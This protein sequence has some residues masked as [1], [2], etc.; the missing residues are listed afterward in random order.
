MFF[1]GYNIYLLELI[2]SLAFI[3]LFIYLEWLSLIVTRIFEFLSLLLR[4]HSL[5]FL[6][7]PIY[8][9]SQR[10]RSYFLSP[11]SISRQMRCLRSSLRQ[12]GC[13]KYREG[14]LE[15]DSCHAP[16][17]LCTPIAFG[18]VPLSFQTLWMPTGSQR[19]DVAAP[20]PIHLDLL[21]TRTSTASTDSPIY[22]QT[23]PKRDV[24]RKELIWD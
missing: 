19:R 21:H 1:Y 18:N 23:D 6:L 24:E 10:L 8:N 16:A 14:K 15:R 13:N 12:L 4:H 17:C 9:G 7:E 11:V 2:Y 20:I 3:Y 5:P 22:S